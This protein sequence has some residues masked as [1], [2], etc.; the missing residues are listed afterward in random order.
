MALKIL[1]ADESI[2]DDGKDVPMTTPAATTTTKEEN[3]TIAP[4]TVLA[5]AADIDLTKT[6]VA[7][8]EQRLKDLAE[9]L[10]IAMG[11]RPRRKSAP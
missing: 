3:P 2:F 11:G 6:T 8:G 5:I 9:E 7:N 10:R 1:M 4:R